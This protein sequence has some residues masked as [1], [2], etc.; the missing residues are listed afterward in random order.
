MNPWTSLI[1]PPKMAPPVRS[2]IR[3]EPVQNGH[4]AECARKLLSLGPLPW[5]EFLAI[6]GWPVSAASGV[7][8]RLKSTG[9]ACREDGVWRLL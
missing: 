6:T 7:L 9:Q 8:G 5:G 2:V 4:R 3:R 1:D